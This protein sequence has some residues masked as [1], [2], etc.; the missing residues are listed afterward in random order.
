[1][2]SGSHSEILA[3]L[4]YM[5]YYLSSLLLVLLVLL[6]LLFLLLLLSSSSS[7]SSRGAQMCTTEFRV[8][9]MKFLVFVIS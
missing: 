9:I 8:K 5:N 1:M 6:L 7:S 2:F 3:G 4:K